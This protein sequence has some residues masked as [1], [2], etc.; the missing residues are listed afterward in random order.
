MCSSWES[1]LMLGVL[2]GDV[3]IPDLYD[4]NKSITGW[5]HWFVVN[6]H[7][8]WI[9]LSSHLPGKK[10]S[11][12]A[13]SST[14][15]ENKVGTIMSNDSDTL[16][17]RKAN[18]IRKSSSL[19]ICLKAAYFYPHPNFRGRSRGLRWQ[20]ESRAGIQ[21]AGLQTKAPHLCVSWEESKVLDSA[22]TDVNPIPGFSS[23][24][25]GFGLAIRYLS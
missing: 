14:S 16:H 11:L 15:W 22:R 7:P 9:D 12:N 5:F 8:G 21:A 2:S 1:S 19:S 24:L 23:L 10:K 17:L 4:A 20:R 6:A 13:R 18:S 25:L 3:P